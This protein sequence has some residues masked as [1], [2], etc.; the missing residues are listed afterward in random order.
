MSTAPLVSSELD[1]ARFVTAYLLVHLL[2]ETVTIRVVGPSCT[3]AETLFTLIADSGDTRWKG[4]EDQAG[5]EIRAESE[6][7]T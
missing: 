2:I 6:T 5:E 4:C 7:K 1:E 3:P